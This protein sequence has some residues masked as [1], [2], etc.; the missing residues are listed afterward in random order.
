MARSSALAIRGP[1]VRIGLFFGFTAITLTIL[2]LQ[3]GNIRFDS[4]NTYQAVVSSTSGLKS[5][6]AV[7]IAG[8]EVGKVT[9]IETT[10]DNQGLI[11]FT[12]PT[13]YPVYKSTRAMVRYKNLT[14]DHFLQ[15]A[16]GPGSNELLPDDGVIPESQ[17][18]P[19]LDLDVLL[20]GF[21][22]LLQGLDPGQL[23]QLTNS[24]VQVLQGQGG[25]IESLF[26][27]TSALTNGLADQDQVIGALV[28][29]LNTVLETTNDHS[30]QLDQ[31]IVG[32]QQLVSGLNGD[33]DKITGSL[34]SINR[35]TGS[36]AS[37]L[38]QARPPL[39]GTLAQLGRTSTQ[40]NKGQD[41]VNDVLKQL[42]GLYYRMTRA[43]STG[44]FFNF[45]LCQVTVKY[46]N[47][48]APGGVGTLGPIGPNPG[49]QR[50]ND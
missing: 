20:Q 22:P 42:P 11:T 3:F 28:N 25:T 41:D 2:V 37:L 39:K 9:K 34:G 40:L 14:G 46:T 10:P 48:V 8:Y 12:V 13:K 16:E 23:N 43:G 26:S 7:L 21:S 44:S 35:L 36:L 15:L 49:T 1:L 6:E 18:A 29:N 45:Y 31:T 5:N 30:Q 50:C 19:A 32:L 27:S 38:Q 4:S 47:P 17:T 33:R 24:L